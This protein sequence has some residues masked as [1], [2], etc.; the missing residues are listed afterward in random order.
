[1]IE[2]GERLMHP[3]STGRRRDGKYKGSGRQEKRGEHFKSHLFCISGSMTDEGEF[4]YVLPDA[5]VTSSIF[6]A[7]QRLLTW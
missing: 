3:R 7:Q 1:M 5:H 2:V 4:H 6:R